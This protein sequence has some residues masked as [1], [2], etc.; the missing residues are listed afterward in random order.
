VKLAAVTFAA[1]LLAPS[2]SF[3]AAAHPSFSCTGTLNPTE[4]VICSDDSLA[5]LDRALATAFRNKFDGLPVESADALDEVVKS[6]VI[7]QKAWLAHRNSCGTDR[8]CIYKAYMVRK[9]AL[10]AGDD[11]K[12]TPCRD[13][14][15]AE[16]AAI[17]VKE[18]IAVGSETHP[19][20]NAD[21]SCELIVSHNIF[22]CAGLGDGAPK[23]C[24]A[25]TKP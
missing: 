8:G 12:D 20:C 18:C 15:G 5:A 7:T 13:T 10:I 22:R 3:A 24:D 17:Y 19:P 11:A 16:Q 14:V 23:F 21:N 9:G 1:V 2:A 6:L 25:Y 4:T